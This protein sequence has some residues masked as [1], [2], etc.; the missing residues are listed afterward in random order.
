M[1]AR[2]PW[3]VP[4]PG[5]TKLHRMEESLGTA[6]VGLTKVDLRTI[7]AV[8]EQ[9]DMVDGRY[10]AAA[11]LPGRATATESRSRCGSIC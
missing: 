11:Q 8:L 6:Q 7:G 1:P 3:I 4:I 5:T 9:V 2:K 10:S